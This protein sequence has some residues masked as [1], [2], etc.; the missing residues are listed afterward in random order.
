MELNP[1]KYLYKKEEDKEDSKKLG[2][3]FVV[4]VLVLMILFAG[5]LSLVDSKREKE[6]NTKN[7]SAEQKIE[8]DIQQIENNEQDELVANNEIL[9]NKDD[10]ISFSI[11]PSSKVSGVQSYN[12]TIKG[13]YFFEGN[14]LINIL[15][16]NKNILKN[17]NAMAKTDWMT[18]GPVDFEGKMDFTG[19]SKGQ[20]YIEIRQ[21]DPSGGES[22]QP[23]KFILVPIIIN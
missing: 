21:D 11:L 18:S 23:E 7:N 4:I 12:G 16:V 15:D 3:P 5:I 20:A 2:T 13:G 19:F 10:L 8:K 1:L 6:E 17:S 9:G 14:I 22:G